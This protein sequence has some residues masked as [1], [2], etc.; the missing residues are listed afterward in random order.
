ML[1]IIK[2]VVIKI[3]K[4]VFEDLI[5]ESWNLLFTSLLCYAFWY[6]KNTRFVKLLFHHVLYCNNMS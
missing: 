4:Q 6:D 5:S 1:K 3:H 2:Y